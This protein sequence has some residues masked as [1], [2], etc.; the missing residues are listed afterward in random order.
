MA[1][2]TICP[3]HC[4]L[5]EGMIGYC[6]S[7]ICRD[8]RVVSLSY[9]R[10]TSLALDPIEKKP[11]VHFYPGSM[12][13]SLGTFGCNMRCP[14]CQN[15][16][17]SQVSE[18]EVKTEAVSPEEVA[19]IA[20]RLVPR[21][22]IGVA[23]TYNEP[24]VGYEFVRDTARL[25]HRMGM[26]NVLV[27]NGMAERDVLSEVLPHIDALNI[28]LKCFAPEGYRSL[29]GDLECVKSTI[30]QCIQM[31]K[32]V[33]LTSLIVP[34]LND[35]KEEIEKECRWIASVDRRIVLH[36]TRFFPRYRMGNREPTSIQ[37]VHNLASVAR[38]Y[39]DSVHVGNC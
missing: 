11:L 17:I 33:E 25:V 24:L 4:N 10:L 37:L 38:T 32:H 7:R 36:V 26:V 8:G 39:L 23:F 30:E 6:R 14:F 19:E 16:S 5:R 27:T 13:L 31:G 2:C 15:A 1:E 12:I 35:R 9:G 20:R 3:H 28:D 34:G 21:G 22:N 18:N 29:G